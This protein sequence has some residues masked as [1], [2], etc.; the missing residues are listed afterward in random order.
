[1]I[2]KYERLAEEALM[3]KEDK[4]KALQERADKLEKELDLSNKES[5]EVM[6]SFK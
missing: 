1:M 3:S 2:Q 5:E 4:M 6:Q